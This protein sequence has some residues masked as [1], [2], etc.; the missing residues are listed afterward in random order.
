MRFARFPTQLK[1]APD[2]PATELEIHLQALAV[3]ST[4]L[5]YS[6]AHELA[7]TSQDILHRHSSR[8]YALIREIRFLPGLERFMLG[9]SFETLC[10]TAATHPVIVLVGARDRHYALII[11]PPQLDSHT[12]ISLKLTDADLESLSYTPSSR[13]ARRCADASDDVQLKVERA[14]FNAS[15]RSYSGPFDGQ[16]K[17]MWHKVVKPVLERLGLEVSEHYHKDVSKTCTNG[18]RSYRRTTIVLA[19]IGVLLGYSAGSHYMQLVSIM[20]NTRCAAV[21]LWCH[22]TPLP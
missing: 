16:R 2:T 9:E 7:L 18:E 20:E 17:T 10:T 21:I 22:R 6:R 15:A 14:P 11:A 13:G 5:A 19:C 1:D 12:L 8:A 4:S 3:R